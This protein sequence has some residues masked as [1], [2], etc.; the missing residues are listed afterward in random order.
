MLAA[1]LLA[2]RLGTS[3]SLDR[4][5]AIVR[6]PKSHKFDFVSDDGRRVVECKHHIARAAL[7]NDVRM[8][9]QQ[10]QFTQHGDDVHLKDLAKTISSRVLLQ[11]FVVTWDF[12]LFIRGRL[13]E[14]GINGSMLFP[15]LGALAENFRFDYGR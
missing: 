9:V 12:K 11:H 13:S 1:K 8:V 7:Q 14:Y 15:D 5:I 4:P 6:S 10:S 2:A 3:L